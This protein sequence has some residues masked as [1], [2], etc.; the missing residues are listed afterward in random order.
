MYQIP[1]RRGYIV[2]SIPIA[3]QIALSPDLNTEGID[4]VVQQ[5]Y[6]YGLRSLDEASRAREFVGLTYSI[7]KPIP[8]VKIENVLRHNQDKLVEWGKE[9]RKEAAIASNQLVSANMEEAGQ[10]VDQYQIEIV[11]QNHDERDPTPALSEGIKVSSMPRE[12][13]VAPR[14]RTRGKR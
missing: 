12:A 13:P 10:R 11:E 14:A 5:H 2:Q 7:D 3:S 8:G 1:E 4:M 9:I 6:K